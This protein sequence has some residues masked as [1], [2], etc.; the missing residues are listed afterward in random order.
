MTTVTRAIYSLD[1]GNLRRI[2]LFLFIFIVQWI[3]YLP[4]P[5]YDPKDIG[6]NDIN[7]ENKMVK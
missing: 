5:E 7:Y 2:Q 3:E 1:R 6:K 4:E